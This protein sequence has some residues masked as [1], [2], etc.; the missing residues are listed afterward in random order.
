M[1]HTYN[2]NASA[3]S[4]MSASS[5]LMLLACLTLILSGTC[6]LLSYSLS[7]LLI[8][9][10]ISPSLTSLKLLFNDISKYVLIFSIFLLIISF[11]CITFRR[12]KHRIIHMIRKSLYYYPY[13]NPLFLKDG[14]IL[15]IIKC[16]KINS[17]Q[18]E[19]IFDIG[20]STIDDIQDLPE[21]I[22]SALIKKFSNYAVINF[23]TDLA[24]NTIT[25]LLDDVTADKSLNIN[26]SEELKGARPTLIPIQ[27]DV[28]IDLETSGSI[29]LSGKTRS[30]KSTAAIAILISAL[31]WGRD[32]HKSI[33]TII[34][35]KQAELSRLP[36][37]I[38]LDEDGL[39]HNILN[40]IREFETTI[41][42]RQKYLNDL[43]EEKGDAI[44]WWDAKMH[45]S[46]LFIDEFVACRSLFPTRK[47]KENADYNQQIFDDLLKRI[48]TM[49]ASA[50]CFVM[51]SIAEASVQEGGLPAM[52]RS[53]MST[54]ILMKPTLSEARLIW[55]SVKL[56][57]VNTTRVYNAGDAWFSSTD[58]IHDEVNFVHFPLMQFEVYR[59]LGR[60]L[61]Q[62]YQ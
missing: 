3:V 26:S 38:T 58:G 55:D 13:G 20:A 46:F 45:V 50:G 24:Y 40:S 27:Q 60:L 9:M 49:G 57:T 34:D 7:I 56:E 30:G 36:H 4:F 42:E 23:N 2:K 8:K 47:T 48:V 11:V 15:P 19:L 12:D 22:S 53:A 32:K 18:Y 59:E 62:Y 33:I 1:K 39:A 41:K 5:K 17:F 31:L 35:P 54:K 52:L 51:I 44:K 14:E 37:V 25:F 43:S 6:K 29:L 16:K 10:S 28:S 21:I 61:K